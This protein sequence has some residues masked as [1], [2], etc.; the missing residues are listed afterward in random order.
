[1]TMKTRELLCVFVVIFFV[2]REEILIKGGQN[3]KIKQSLNQNAVISIDKKND[4]FLLIGKGVGFSKKKGDTVKLNESIKIYP[5]TY[6]EQEQK[7]LE[8]ID[9]I[10]S[11]LVLM[12]EETIKEAEQ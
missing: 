9:E 1:M 4:E 3:I 7:I 5:M 10:P 2:F 12:V 11:E 6:S 8:L